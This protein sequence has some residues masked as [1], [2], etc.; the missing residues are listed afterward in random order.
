MCQIYVFDSLNCMLN[1][2]NIIWLVIINEMNKSKISLIWPAC[3]G[4][5]CNRLPFDPACYMSWCGLGSGFGF[6]KGVLG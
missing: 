4:L 1:P 2:Q 6:E 5:Q 3:T